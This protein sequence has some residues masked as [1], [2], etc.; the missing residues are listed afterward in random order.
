MYSRSTVFYVNLYIILT[1]N[2][3]SLNLGQPDNYAS[4]EDCGMITIGWVGG[5]V[6]NDSPCITEMNFICERKKGNI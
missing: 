4:N 2:A 3:F 1:Y 6:W 5:H